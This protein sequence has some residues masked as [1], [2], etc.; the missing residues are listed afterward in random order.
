LR[1]PIQRTRTVLIRG[2]AALATA[3]AFAAC[4]DT[5]KRASS[6]RVVVEVDSGEPLELVVSTDFVMLLDQGSGSSTPFLNNRDS[7]SLSADYQE[8]YALDQADPRF[9]A[10]LK[11]ESA[12][13]EAVHMQVFL[14]GVEAYDVSITMANGG[15]L[16]YI[17]QFNTLGV[18]GG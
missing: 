6:A 9:Y 5:A 2:V 10:Q 8:D 12:T 18:T 17:Y 11:N 1:N 7:V 15:Y 16:E 13:P 4:A 14:D 3:L